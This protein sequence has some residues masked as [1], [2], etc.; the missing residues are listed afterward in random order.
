M[1]QYEEACWHVEAC[2]E[3]MNQSPVWRFSDAG[4]KRQQSAQYYEYWCRY[5]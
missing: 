5:M 4:E 3:Y 2:K 1:Y